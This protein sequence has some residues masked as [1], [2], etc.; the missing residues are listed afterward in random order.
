[1]RGCKKW[2]APAARFAV[3]GLRLFRV[4][5]SEL[6]YPQMAH[7]ARQR[8]DGVPKARPEGPDQ[9][10]RPRSGR[11]GL[12]ICADEGGGGLGEAALPWGFYL[13]ESASSVD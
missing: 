11:A 6:Y 5:S 7:V 10:G 1:M 13:C 12:Q 8:G 9:T 4:L 2:R 3:Y